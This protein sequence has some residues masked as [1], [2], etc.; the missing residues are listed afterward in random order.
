MPECQGGAPPSSIISISRSSRIR[1]PGL[2]LSK[3]GLATGGLLNAALTPLRCGTDCA[4]RSAKVSAD[5][6]HLTSQVPSLSEHIT[7]SFDH[8]AKCQCSTVCDT[9]SAPCQA[10]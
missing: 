8:C 7:L 1:R 5:V 4:T 2:E 3:P 9:P 10:V 6:R